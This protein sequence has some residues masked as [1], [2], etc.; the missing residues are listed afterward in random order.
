MAFIPV[1][2]TRAQSTTSSPALGPT[3]TSSQ[4]KSSSISQPEDKKIFRLYAPGKFLKCY[5]NW[6]FSIFLD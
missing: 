1:D 6:F 5:D 3:T 4:D 2:E